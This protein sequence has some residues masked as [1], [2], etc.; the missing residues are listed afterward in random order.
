M[1]RL[2]LLF[3]LSVPSVF[4][5]TPAAPPP[6]A[7]NQTGVPQPMPV[8][9]S[10]TS[11]R[12]SRVI[13][14]PDGHAQGLLLRNGT[15]VNLAPGLSQQ[16]PSDLRRNLRVNVS[17]AAYGVG[18]DRTIQAQQLTIAGIT[19]N[20]AAGIG[21]GPVGRLPQPSGMPAPPPPGATGIAPPPPPPLPGPAGAVPPPRGGLVAPPPP[22]PGMASPPAA[23]D[24]SAVSPAPNPAAVPAPPPTAGAPAPAPPPAPQPP[25]Q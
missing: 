1:N 20:D 14:G 12:I 4:A 8:A 24:A 2:L 7:P 11:S 25:P 18:T 23:P 16:I 19:Y 9:S 21:A 22:P 17:G 3:A 5:K 6:P 10:A 13:A 15:F